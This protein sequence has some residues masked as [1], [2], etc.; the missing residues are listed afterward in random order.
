M[1]YLLNTTIMPNEGI[2]SNHKVSR[3]AAERWLRLY[4]KEDGSISYTSALGHQGSAEAFNACFPFLKCEVNRIPSTMQSGDEAIALKVLGRI[5][6]GQILD[7]EALEAVG[8]EFYHIR[9]F[10]LDTELYPAGTQPCV[11]HMGGC[12]TFVS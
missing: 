11:G 6:E 8:Y 2:Y 5:Q 1:L 3:D 12:S 7:L 9:C 10:P 4:Q